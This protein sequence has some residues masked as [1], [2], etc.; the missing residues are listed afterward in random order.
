VKVGNEKESGREANETTTTPKS[1]RRIAKHN[2][3]LTRM[4]D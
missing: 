4:G 2:F 3:E 1:M